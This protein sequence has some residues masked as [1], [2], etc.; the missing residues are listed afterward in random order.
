MP[1]ITFPTS[2]IRSYDAKQYH[3]WKTSCKLAVHK[4]S[5]GNDQWTDEI[6]ALETEFTIQTVSEYTDLD[7]FRLLRNF[8]KF[9]PRISA[10]A[11]WL[12]VSTQFPQSNFQKFQNFY[13]LCGH[14]KEDFERYGTLP[15]VYSR[16]TP[17][18][19][20]QVC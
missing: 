7:K 20:E 6:V 4:V 16:I 13:C 10:H 12:I 8:M 15:G 9:V 14:W 3:L 19:A 11:V 17:R 5:L 1:G 18:L 2:G